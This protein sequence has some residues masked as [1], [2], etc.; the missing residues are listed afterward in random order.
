MN[1]SNIRRLIEQ[2]GFTFKRFCDKIG[3]T[4]QGFEPAI[5]KETV[6]LR[7]LRKMSETLDIPI[8]RFF[9]EPEH[10]Q[11]LNSKKV[12]EHDQNGL[13]LIPFEFMAGFGEDNSGIILNECERYVIPEF[14]N[15]GAEYLIRVGGSSMYPKYSSGD[16]LACKKIKDILFFQWGKVY[17]IDSSQG[18]MVKRI[19]EHE[20][21]DM[22]LI[23]SDN[24]EKYPPFVMPKI[25]IRSI[26]I[27]VGAV[28][29]E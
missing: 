22:I 15:L 29:I 17:V 5:N 7:V 4:P 16:I 13:P 19:F 3:M 9:D 21:K 2:K 25:D 24:K 14:E 11:V 6:P 1:Y 27:V 20:N 18:Q 26:S 23:V 12:K 8:S 10:V 28:R